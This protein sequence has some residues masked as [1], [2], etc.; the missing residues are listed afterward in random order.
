MA[1][2]GTRSRRRGPAVAVT[3]W[4]RAATVTAVMSVLALAVLAALPYLAGPGSPRRWSPCSC[5]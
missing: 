3:R 4:S 2:V 1:P 5:W